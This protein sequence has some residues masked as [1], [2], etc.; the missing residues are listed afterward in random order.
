MFQKLNVTE[1]I[2]EHLK[3]FLFKILEIVQNKITDKTFFKIP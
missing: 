3:P 1:Y 2:K